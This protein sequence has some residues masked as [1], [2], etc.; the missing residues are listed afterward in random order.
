M[1]E[2]VQISEEE[3]LQT[4]KNLDYKIDKGVPISIGSAKQPKEVRRI[5][6]ETPYTD[7]IGAKY[8]WQSKQANAQRNGIA[9]PT[10]AFGMATKG[11]VIRASSIDKAIERVNLIMSNTDEEFVYFNVKTP[12]QPVPRKTVIGESIDWYV[13][14][15]REY[16]RA[17]VDNRVRRDFY[18]I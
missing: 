4:I 2:Y 17:R 16:I 5:L 9:R 15:K 10:E 1:T 18:D 12:D 11:Y 6:S 7:F 14:R 8:L 3:R 13:N